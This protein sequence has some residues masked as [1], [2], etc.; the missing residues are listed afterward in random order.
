MVLRILN[1]DG[2]VNCIIVSKDTAVLPPFFSQQKKSK[3]L[4][5]GMLGVYPEAIDWTIVVRTQISFWVSVSE[6]K[7]LS[8]PKNLQ[9]G[10][11]FFNF[12]GDPTSDMVAQN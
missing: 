12:W 7:A 4:T 6:V 10:P 1:P 11:Y 3:T 8:E 2:Q 9:N 5:I